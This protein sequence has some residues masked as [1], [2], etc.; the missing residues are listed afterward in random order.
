MMQK[1]V[2]VVD[3]EPSVNTYLSEGLSRAG[4]LVTT[5]NDASEAFTL[6]VDGVEA[7]APIDLLLTDSNMPHLTGLELVEVLRREGLELP[8]LLM[9]GE[10]SGSL[11]IEALSRG[12][13]GF[14]KKPFSVPVLAEHIHVALEAGSNWGSMWRFG[15]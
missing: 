15:T 5:A 13:P 2:L 7:P 14:I 11:A 6:L 10:L 1:H 3:D 8:C 4:F 12:C 9:S